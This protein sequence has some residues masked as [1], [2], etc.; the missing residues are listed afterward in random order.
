MSNVFFMGGQSDKLVRIMKTEINLVRD[1]WLV[2]HQDLQSV[3]RI[4][5]VIDFITDTMRRDREVLMS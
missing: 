2:V 3:P 1:W 5:A 4:R